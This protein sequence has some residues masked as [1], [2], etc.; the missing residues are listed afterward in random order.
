M[1]VGD[2]EEK[3]SCDGINHH[4]GGQAVFGVAVGSPGVHHVIL[5]VVWGV[6]VGVVGGE[7]AFH[8]GIVVHVVVG[9]RVVGVSGMVG[10]CSVGVAVG[11]VG[12]VGVLYA[13]WTLGGLYGALVSLLFQSFLHTGGFRGY[14]IN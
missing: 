14:C 8:S 7:G 13:G 10:V 12:E 5:A 3:S 1:R 6:I 2:L 4:R 11:M 9:V